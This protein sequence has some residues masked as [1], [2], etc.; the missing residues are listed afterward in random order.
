MIYIKQCSWQLMPSRHGYHAYNYRRETKNFLW[1]TIWQHFETT[2]RNCHILTSTESCEDLWFL[3][4]QHLSGILIYYPNLFQNIFVELGK[5]SR[6]TQSI[7]KWR[8]QHIN[9][10]TWKEYQKP[11][12]ISS[13]W[14]FR[15]VTK[16][17]NSI[18]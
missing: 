2:R 16:M 12:G 13:P 14:H 9:Y 18:G 5:G 17:Q 10:C 1:N 11:L 6:S 3:K 7:L 15:V 8:K 4:F